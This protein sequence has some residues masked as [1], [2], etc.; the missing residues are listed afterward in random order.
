MALYFCL[1]R[2]G[3]AIISIALTT[4][5]KITGVLSFKNI[6][7]SLFFISSN[8]GEADRWGL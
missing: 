6:S 8:G 5:V 2:P 3:V 4:D 1:H 7:Q